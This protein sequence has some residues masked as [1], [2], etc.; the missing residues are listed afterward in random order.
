VGA[1]VMV[2]GSP[3]LTALLEGY[4]CPSGEAEVS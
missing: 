2:G 1:G 3:W 4:T